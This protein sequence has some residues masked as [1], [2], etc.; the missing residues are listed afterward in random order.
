M[1]RCKNLD[2]GLFYFLLFFSL[3]ALLSKK[4]KIPSITRKEPTP[5]GEAQA[6][7][8]SSPMI[9]ASINITSFRTRDLSSK[10]I[11]FQPKIRAGGL[12]Y[13]LCTIFTPFTSKPSLLK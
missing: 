12:A 10:N 9:N 5:K 11:L 3:S 6:A 2:I 4:M 7:G 13:L 8:L 1:L